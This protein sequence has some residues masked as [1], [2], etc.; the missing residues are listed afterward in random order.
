MAGRPDA[1]AAQ[2]AEL[3]E[4]LSLTARARSF[5]SL[6]ATRLDASYR[7]ARAILGEPAEAEDAVHDAFVS[8]WLH[9][10]DLRDHA[11]FEAW[12]DRIVVNTCRNRLKSRSRIRVADI[13]TE[14][15]VRAPGDPY[16]AIHD[17]DEIRQALDTLDADHLI[18]VTLRFYA[19]LTVD[20]IAS[21]T[22]LRS[23]T[24]KSRLHYAMRKLEAS[25]GESESPEVAR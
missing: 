18:V 1:D 15:A 5:R 3:R 19:D 11:R 7:L 22:G 21:R 24:V 13:S 4:G 2:P 14:L 12:F 25:L 17:R 23:G 8:A 10:S 6:A 9:W 16:R 20:Q